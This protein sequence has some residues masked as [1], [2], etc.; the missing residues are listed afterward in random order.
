MNRLNPH[1]EH[2]FILWCSCEKFQE[3]T[4]WL[5]GEMGMNT[6]ITEWSVGDDP[7]RVTP[8]TKDNMHKMFIGEQRYMF[9]FN[10]EKSAIYFKMVWM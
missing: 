10:T 5:I 7:A 4:N 6:Y 9:T 3:I 1:H 8:V 2:K